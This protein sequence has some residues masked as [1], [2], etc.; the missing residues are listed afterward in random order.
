MTLREI[1]ETHSIPR[2]EP[3]FDQWHPVRILYHY[4]RL[5]A[6]DVVPETRQLIE[7]LTKNPISALPKSIQEGHTGRVQFLQRCW[8]E[9]KHAASFGEPDSPKSDHDWVMVDLET[10]DWEAWDD[11]A[12][13]KSSLSEIA[14]GGSGVQA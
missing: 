4:M 7:N 10:L 1:E 2:T 11:W 12:V 3:Q 9:S 8:E 5:R 14:Q 13:T 6:H